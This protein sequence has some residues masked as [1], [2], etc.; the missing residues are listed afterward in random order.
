METSGGGVYS[1]GVGGGVVLLDV[2][3]PDLVSA[4]VPS[5]GLLSEG[6]FSSDELLLLCVRGA[7]DGDLWSVA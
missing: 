1:L 4:L 3:L 7:P 6:A 2:S 5:E